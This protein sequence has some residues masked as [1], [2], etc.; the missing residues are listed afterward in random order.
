[1]L[2][3]FALH[4]A[5]APPDAFRVNEAQLDLWSRWFEPPTPDELGVDLALTETL[6]DQRN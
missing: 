2:T 6:L 5:A 4:N 1:M 3:R